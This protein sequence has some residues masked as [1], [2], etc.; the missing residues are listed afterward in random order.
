MGIFD[1]KAISVVRCLV[2]LE[3]PDSASILHLGRIKSSFF[4][5]VL[6]LLTE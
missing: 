2:N 1:L 5:R 3:K 4:K 6:K